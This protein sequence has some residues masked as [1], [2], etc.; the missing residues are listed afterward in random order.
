MK[1]RT[2]QEC[3]HEITR[4]HSN[5]HNCGAQIRSKPLRAIIIG[6]VCGL[7]ATIILYIAQDSEFTWFS[8]PAKANAARLPEPKHTKPSPADAPPP[9]PV[10][11]NYITPAGS[12]ERLVED[13]ALDVLGVRLDDP[14][15]NPSIISIEKKVPADNAANQYQIE[16]HYRLAWKPTG[17]QARNEMLNNVGLL[18][19][20]IFSDPNLV[21]V[22]TLVLYPSL[23]VGDPYQPQSR[24]EEPAGLLIIR[25]DVAERTDWHNV[26]VRGVEDMLQLEDKFWLH[27]N[28]NP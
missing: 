18:I 9:A 25:R 20:R 23:Q 5:C 28:L 11:P 6:L 3:G 13:I 12:V 17:S 1:T 27:T 4:A 10:M 2:C 7:A 22:S 24:V 26:D 14:T 21:Q 8:G 16:I 15:L 19:E